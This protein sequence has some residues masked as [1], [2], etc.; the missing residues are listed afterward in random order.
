MSIET[1]FVNKNTT[2]NTMLLDTG[3]QVAMIQGHPTN[4][5]NLKI[6]TGLT[7]GIRRKL[8]PG[9]WV[10]RSLTLDDRPSC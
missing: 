3:S 9:T 7:E 8:T 5:E 10:H 1:S 2:Y 6:K 4:I